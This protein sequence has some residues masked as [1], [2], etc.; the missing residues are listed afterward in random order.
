MSC[1]NFSAIGPGIERTL[2]GGAMRIV[3]LLC[4]GS[5]IAAL[6]LLVAC[7]PGSGQPNMD[8]ALSSLQ[9]A[10][11]S[12]ERAA[13]DKGGHRVRALELVNQAIGEVEMGIQ[14]GAQR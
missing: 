11:G 2:Q 5:I 3:R 7:A 10:R 1:K 8:S 4:S 6:P 13:H 9:S 14:A 12:L